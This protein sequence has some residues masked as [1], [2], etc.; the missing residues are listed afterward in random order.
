MKRNVLEWTRTAVLKPCSIEFSFAVVIV[1]K[2][3]E[4]LI[5]CNCGCEKSFR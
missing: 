1:L 5:K 3:N 4:H 2:D